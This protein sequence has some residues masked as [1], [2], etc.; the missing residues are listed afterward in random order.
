VQQKRLHQRLAHGS[1]A[2]AIE[3]IFR[4]ESRRQEGAEP[5]SRLAFT[6]CVAA[7]R[8]ARKLAGAFCELRGIAD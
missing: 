4:C 5:F 1:K 2:H 6:Q 8:L 3:M 7:R